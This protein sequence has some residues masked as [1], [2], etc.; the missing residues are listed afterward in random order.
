ML[1]VLNTY[2]TKW[3]NKRVTMYCVLAQCSKVNICTRAYKSKQD[4]I[5]IY[6]IVKKYMS[7]GYN[8]LVEIAE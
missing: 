1:Y 7:P 5:Y 6:I 4:T 8:R 2:N 3:S